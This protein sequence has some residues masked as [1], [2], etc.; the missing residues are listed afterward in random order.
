MKHKQVTTDNQR[1]KKLQTINQ[2]K[3]DH[4]VNPRKGY[5]NWTP[6]LQQYTS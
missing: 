4:L 2:A 6:V 5:E 1:L 3:S